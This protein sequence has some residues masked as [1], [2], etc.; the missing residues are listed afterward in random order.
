MSR[1]LFTVITVDRHCKSFKFKFYN[2]LQ[3]KKK[4]QSSI[5]FP[6]ELRDDSRGELLRTLDSISLNG[7]TERAL[8]KLLLA[9]IEFDW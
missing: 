9:Q 4:I 8:K 7:I 2:A 1:S 5:T 6:Q 3:L